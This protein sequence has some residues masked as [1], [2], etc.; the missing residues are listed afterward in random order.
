L[1]DSDYSDVSAIPSRAVHPAGSLRVPGKAALLENLWRAVRPHQ[2]A[3]NLLLMVALGTSHRYGEWRATS[4]ALLAVL[5]FSLASSSVYLW[6][7]IL[8]RSADRRHPIKCKRPIASGALSLPI[9]ILVATLCAGVSLV[10]SALLEPRLALVIGAYML[11]SSLYSLWLK[12][13]L[14]V[15]VVVLACLYVVRVIAGGLAIGVWLSF[16]TLA[17]SLF[18]FFGLALAKRYSELRNRAGTGDDSSQR[19]AYLVAD[20]SQLNM[21]GVASSLVAVCIVGLYIDGPEVKQLYTHPDVLW[22]LCPLLLWWCGRLWVLAGRGEVNEDPVAFALRD[23][24]SYI[25]GAL[26][27]LTVIAAT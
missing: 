10:G 15:D 18:F 4:R 23:R 21:L 13:L 16:W 1:T 3:K 20:M 9:A 11:V 26:V 6:N 7:D 25:I 19:R 27:A 8:D 24:R 17:F 5:L 22:L 12:K 2:W 14:M